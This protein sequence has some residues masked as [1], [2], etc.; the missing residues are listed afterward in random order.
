MKI[1]ISARQQ[2]ELLDRADEIMFDYRDRAAIKKY[3]EIFPKV[4]IILNCSKEQNILNWEDIIKIKNLITNE[5]IIGIT[6]INLIPI[7]KDNKL[8]FYLNY[9]ITSYD[10]LN[11]VLSLGSYYVKLGAPLFFDMDNIKKFFPEVKIRLIP[12]VAYDDKYIHESGLYGTWVRPEDLLL[13]NNYI[14][15]VEFQASDP[16]REKALFHIYIEEQKWPGELD[17]LITNFN[18]PGENAFISSEFSE[19]R[20]N[21][22]QRC[23]ARQGCKICKRAM[24]IADRELIEDYRNTVIPKYQAPKEDN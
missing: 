15:T 24:L 16:H 5:L 18:G 21:C 14:E 10:E 2:K 6:D 3:C 13:Y 22:R 17:M 12:N 20:L 19:A 7:C 8:K 1:C 11:T 4:T 9:P 23:M